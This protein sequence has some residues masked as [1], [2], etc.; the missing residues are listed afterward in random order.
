MKRTQN[1]ISANKAGMIIPKALPTVLIIGEY[2][3][4]LT[5]NDW[6]ALWKP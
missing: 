1:G 4:W 3:G 6:K 2:L 5:P